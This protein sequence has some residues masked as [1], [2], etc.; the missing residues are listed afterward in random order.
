ALAGV[1]PE[2]LDETRLGPD[3]LAPGQAGEG[4]GVVEPEDLRLDPRC[5]EPLA[6]ERI[7]EQAGAGTCLPE[8]V[9][10]FLLTHLLAPD[11]AAAAL[12]GEGRVRHPPPLVLR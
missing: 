8:Q 11:E 1:R 3:L 12:V 10:R 7:V 9:D 5:G 2:E 4:A 6:N